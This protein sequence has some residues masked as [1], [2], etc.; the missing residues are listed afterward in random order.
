MKDMRMEEGCE[1]KRSGVVTKFL[2]RLVSL[3][4][5]CLMLSSFDCLMPRVHFRTLMHAVMYVC[6]AA[7]ANKHA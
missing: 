4:D 5:L 6:M 2:C 7:Y 3:S 1:R